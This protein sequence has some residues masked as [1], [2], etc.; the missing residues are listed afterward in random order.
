MR[1]K[2]AEEARHMCSAS[3]REYGI[4]GGRK[5]QAA[6]EYV[7]GKSKGKAVGR[8]QNIV[9]RGKAVEG[10]IRVVSRERRMC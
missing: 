9:G 5:S 10:E 3:P 4:P 2:D 7:K 8:E 1:K 6:E